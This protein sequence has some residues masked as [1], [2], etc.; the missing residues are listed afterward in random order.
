MALVTLAALAS[1]VI[2][3]LN[4]QSSACSFFDLDSLLLHSRIM[5]RL[6]RSVGRLTT[7]L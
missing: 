5:T 1:T 4:A 6:Q 2:P 3:L 7:L